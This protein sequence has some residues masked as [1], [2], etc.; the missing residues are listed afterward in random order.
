MGVLT[1]SYMKYQ[2]LIS[3]C[4][5]PIQSPIASSLTTEQF[6]VHF[7]PNSCLVRF[8]FLYSIP[9]VPV[10]VPPSLT[11]TPTQRCAVHHYSQIRNTD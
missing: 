7:N 9:P 4:V 1:K 8:L 2:N 10:L 3:E 6:Q 11:Y 5:G